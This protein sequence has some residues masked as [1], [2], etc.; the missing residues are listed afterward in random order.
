MGTGYDS[1]SATEEMKRLLDI[2]Y[3]ADILRS[4]QKIIFNIYFNK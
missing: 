2:S 4:I 1:N 3:N